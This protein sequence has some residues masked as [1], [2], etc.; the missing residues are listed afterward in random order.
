MIRKKDG[1]TALREAHSARTADFFKGKI[2]ASRSLP[3]AQ[4]ESRTNGSFRLK[5]VLPVR[6]A[7]SLPDERQ[8]LRRARMS[9]SGKNLR[10][11]SALTEEVPENA[12]AS[13]C[14][15]SLGAGSAAQGMGGI[16]QCRHGSEEKDAPSRKAFHEGKHGGIRSAAPGPEAEDPSLEATGRRLI[17]G[18]CR[19]GKTPGQKLG[20][21]PRIARA[22][23]KNNGVAHGISPPEGSGAAPLRSE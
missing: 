5:T 23:R 16:R 20:H 3:S 8:P 11:Q 10:I 19:Q 9:A 12:A 22:G 2:C 6:M 1:E 17:H 18:K 21:G 13:P 15:K 4:A 7:G 14:Q